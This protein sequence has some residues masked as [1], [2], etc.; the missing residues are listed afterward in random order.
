MRTRIEKLRLGLSAVVELRLD[1][2]GASVHVNVMDAD[3]A[4]VS[5]HGLS[6]DEL[7][8]FA[9]QVPGRVEKQRAGSTFWLE[10]RFGDVVLTAFAKQGAVC[11]M[12][13]TGTRVVPAQPE[14]VEEIVEWICDEPILAG[15]SLA[16]D[17]RRL[18]RA[19]LEAGITDETVL[20]VE[21]E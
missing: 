12:D 13:V 9:R 5:L 10:G 7:A 21:E 15:A 1:G 17:T 16:A 11:R 4:R 2:L 3:D 14:R 6:R 8:E 18:D 19:T 20:E